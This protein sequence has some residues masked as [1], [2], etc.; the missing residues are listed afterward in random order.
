MSTNSSILFLGKK[1]KNTK[2]IL[3]KT[4]II[5]YVIPVA[6]KGII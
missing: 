1:I 4:Q 2:N 6:E 3:I 5:L